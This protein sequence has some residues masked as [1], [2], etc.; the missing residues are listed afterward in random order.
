MGSRWRLLSPHMTYAP[1][2][3]HGGGRFQLEVPEHVLRK[4]QPAD[5]ESK[6]QRK[7]FRRFHTQ[8]IVELVEEL[9][10]AEE[11]LEKLQG[12]E[13]RKLFEKFDHSRDI[14]AA[15]VR[16]CSH[17]S[18]ECMHGIS[19][20]SPRVFRLCVSGGDRCGAWP[21]LTPCAL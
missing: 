7:G 10:D 11:K 9:T 3:F 21:C 20:D 18:P 8:T 1:C 16:E 2:S 5:Y 13:M 15:A 17:V 12:D 4:N 14:W 19:N 6:S